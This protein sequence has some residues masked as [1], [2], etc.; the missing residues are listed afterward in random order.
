MITT[1]YEAPSDCHC[2]KPAYRR[3]LAHR[4]DHNA[5]RFVYDT[6][7]ECMSDDDHGSRLQVADAFFTKLDKLEHDLNQ[8]KPELPKGTVQEIVIGYSAPCACDQ[9]GEITIYVSIRA[10][11]RAAEVILPARSIDG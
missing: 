9:Y 7:S 2:G 6:H 8:N 1:G 4:G 3:E 11:S 10:F 5:R